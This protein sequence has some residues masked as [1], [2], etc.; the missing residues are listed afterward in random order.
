MSSGGS[1]VQSQHRGLRE[2][3]QTADGKLTVKRNIPRPPP[4]YFT[5]KATF[6]HRDKYIYIYI[7]FPLWGLTAL[8]FF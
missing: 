7:Y 3:Y 1:P 8:I 5:I 4:T 2:R 6:N